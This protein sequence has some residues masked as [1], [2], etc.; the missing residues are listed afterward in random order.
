MQ[1]NQKVFD[2]RPMLAITMLRTDE[3][4]RRR[5]RLGLTMAQAAERAGFKTAQHWNSIESGWR[6]N[7]Q[8]SSLA[9]VAKALECLMDD[10]F[11]LDE[12]DSRRK[13]RRK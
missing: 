11:S 10:L 5:E 13:P 12:P 1:K 6:P 3:I 7:I 9:A 4:R 8:S 2:S